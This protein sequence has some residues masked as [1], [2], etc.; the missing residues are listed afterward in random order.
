MKKVP[1]SITI[2]GRKVKIKQ[3]NNLVYNGQ[4]CLGLC[5]CD[6]NTIYLEKSVELPAKHDVLIH[7]I[8]HYFLEITGFSQKMS[9]SENEV[10]CQLLTLFYND[11]KKSL[12]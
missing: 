5:D 1:S 3:G 10:M 6:N 4:Q 11:V 7:E 2:L 12:K 9:D 8:G